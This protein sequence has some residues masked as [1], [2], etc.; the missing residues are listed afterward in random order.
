MYDVEVVIPVYNEEA[1]IYDVLLTWTKELNTM[2]LSYRIIALNDGSGDHTAAVLQKLEGNP[3]INV[4]HKKNSGH[5]PTILQGYH[6]AVREAQWVFQVDSDNEME[7]KHFRKVWAERQGYDA[8]IGIREGRAQPLPRKIISFISRLI[9]F[10]FYGS[11]VRDVNCPFRLMQ[12]EVLKP[13]LQRIPEDNFAP[14]VTISGLF[15]LNKKK[16]RNVL[17]PHNQRQTGE[18]SIK[19]WKLIKAA[20]RSFVQTVMI[21]FRMSF[22]KT[23]I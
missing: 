18:V 14:N 22:E 11:G 2:G 8:V 12:S 13:L 3:N 1:C 19:K 4:I 9:V 10:L 17:I 5:G 21:R 7:A 20:M 23:K 16:V 15:V 6:I